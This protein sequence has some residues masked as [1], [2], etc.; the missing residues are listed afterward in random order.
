MTS[1]FRLS[2]TFGQQRPGL[3]DYISTDAK[4]AWWSKNARPSMLR[5]IPYILSLRLHSGENWF[6]KDSRENKATTEREIA[7]STCCWVLALA[8]LVIPAPVTLFTLVICLD[9]FCTHEHTGH[10]LCLF[11]NVV[12]CYLVNYNNVRYTTVDLDVCMSSVLI[13]WKTSLNH[14]IA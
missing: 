9:C 7:S 2:S 14:R 5:G 10:S 13:I 4:D 11:C 3:K 12:T 6:T 8:G 1:I